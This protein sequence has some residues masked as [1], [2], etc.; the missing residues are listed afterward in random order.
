[1]TTFPTELSRMRITDRRARVCLGF[2]A[3]IFGT[4]L[5]C[6]GDLDA[7]KPI[8]GPSQ[9]YWAL[10]LDYHALNLS[11]VAP[12]DTIRLVATA[13]AATG[14]ALPSR[15]AVVFTSSDDSKIRVSPDGLVQAVAPGAGVQVIATLRQ[16]NITHADTALLNVTG[17]SNPPALASLSIH[18]AP[19]D[20]AKRACCL[21]IYPWPVSATDA[22]GQPIPDLA[23]AC[24]SSDPTIV[25][26]VPSCGLIMILRPGRVTLTAN[27]LAYGVPKADTVLF[28]VGYSLAASLDLSQPLGTDTIAAGGFVRWINQTAR[29]ADV[30]FDDPTNVVEDPACECGSGN[31]APFGSADLNDFAA[32]Y[33]SRV[34]PVPGTYHYH[35]NALNTGGTIV[36]IRD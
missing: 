35:S 19:S 11:T 18:P 3:A 20:S 24:Q 8:P 12:Y 34:F 29:L 10:S 26:I 31:I 14:E 13:R 21:D 7:P 9:V 36:V 30:T 32:T 22:S 6:R 28:T 23:V 17:D 4:L 1:M 25:M 27:T 2:A 5:G 15:G 16:G 33:R